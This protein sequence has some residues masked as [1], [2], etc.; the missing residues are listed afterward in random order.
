MMTTGV[1][2]E[3]WW[4][5]RWWSVA[6]VV[7]VTVVVITIRL[8]RSVHAVP[9]PPPRSLW[10]PPL[11]EQ[12]QGGTPV[13]PVTS[14]APSWSR[15]KEALADGVKAEGFLASAHELLTSRG[16][17]EEMLAAQ[18]RNARNVRRGV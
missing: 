1:V 3:Q 2:R 10:T 13:T 5:W 6:A 14:V 12:A 8:S 9:P 4:G 18:A 15:L 11:V 16:A 17:T 7:V